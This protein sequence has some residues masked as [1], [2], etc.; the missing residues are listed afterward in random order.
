MLFLFGRSIP[1]SLSEYFSK[2]AK[3]DGHQVVFASMGEFGDEEPFAELKFDPKG[4]LCVIF[5]SVVRA[6]GFNPSSHY[7]QMLACADNLKRYGARKVWAVNPFAGFMRQDKLRDDRKESLLSHLSGRLMREA[8]IDGMSTIEA[9][10]K[11]AIENYETGLGTGNVLNINPNPLF[12]R[13]VKKLGIDV[14]S[15][16]NP[17]NGADERAAD[18]TERLGLKQR[19]SIDKERSREGTKILGQTGRVTKNTLM[20]DDMASSLGTAKNA[21]ELIHDEGSKQNILLISHPIMTGHAWDHLAKLIEDKKLDRVLFL[22]TFAR[23][24]EFIRFKQQYGHEVAEKIVFLEEEF[25]EM[26]YDHVTNDVVQHPAMRAE[27]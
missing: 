21:I 25:N 10:S 20:I 23:D 24:E 5:Q 17:D 12:A 3:D 16:V 7:M 22:P 18:L 13:V 6:G 4:Q 26:L 11:K 15:V 14:D 8:G 2:R 1:P 27:V 19:V 9:H